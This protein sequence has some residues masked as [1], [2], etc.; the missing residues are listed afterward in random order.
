MLK[1]AKK[2]QIIFIRINGPRSILGYN[3]LVNSVLIMICEIICFAG[4]VP[5][6]VRIVSTYSNSF[7]LCNLMIQ[8][9]VRSD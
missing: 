3:Q 1:F 8:F 6:N 4:F 7:N 2:V 9:L 5:D